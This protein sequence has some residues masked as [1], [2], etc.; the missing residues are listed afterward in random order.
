MEYFRER[1]TE[2]E[3]VEPE[4]PTTPTPATPATIPFYKK[5]N[6]TVVL[7]IAGITIAIAIALFLLYGPQLGWIKLDFGNNGFIAKDQVLDF[8][9]KG[10]YA[11]EK[12]ADWVEITAGEGGASGVIWV[13][14][15]IRHTNCVVVEKVSGSGGDL[16]LVFNPLE[17]KWLKWEDRKINLSGIKTSTPISLSLCYNVNNSTSQARAELSFNLSNKGRLRVEGFKKIS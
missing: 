13:P 4:I 2:A 9:I 6:W 7:T 8:D 3:T 1:R 10:N 11:R 5:I 17:P 15:V 12:G 14:P 16:T